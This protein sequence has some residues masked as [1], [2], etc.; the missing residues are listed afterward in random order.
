MRELAYNA[1]SLSEVGSELNIPVQTSSPFSR[2]GGEGIAAFPGLVNTAFDSDVLQE[3][4]A[5][6]VIELSPT[7][8]VVI[9]LREVLPVRALPLEEVRH[10]I[11]E[12]LKAKA[13]QQIL[14][15]TASDILDRL[16]GGGD[17]EEIAKQEG[18]AWQVSL[19]TKR[20]GGGAVD[21]EVREQAFSLSARSNLPVATSFLSS[22]GD[23]VVL[24]LSQVTPG[25]LDGLPASQK[26]NLLAS[27]QRTLAQRDYQSYEASLV[28]AAKIDTA[29]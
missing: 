5:S 14:E 13:T 12:R 9:K 2:S 29:Y 26:S 20:F 11:E 23:H 8:M 4:H 21:A 19:D 6:D 15:K 7:R 24:S 27:I 25:S 17:I 1:D 16:R 18:F 28:A 22:A 3:G 10:D